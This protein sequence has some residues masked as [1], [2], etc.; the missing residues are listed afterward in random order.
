MLLFGSKVTRVKENEQP[1]VLL[2]VQG[3]SC[4]DLHQILNRVEREFSPQLNLK[5]EM[6]YY[7]NCY[8]LRK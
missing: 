7:V 8:L 2:V 3:Q 1:E 4:H 6:H 5:Y